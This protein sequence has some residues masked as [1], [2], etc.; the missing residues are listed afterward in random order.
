MTFA[1]Y[2]LQGLV[3][4][5]IAL[6]LAVGI[7]LGRLS[8]GPIALDWIKPRIEEALIPGNTDL[9]VTV[10]RTELRLAENHRTIEL[11]GL[12]VSFRSPGEPVFL[13]FPEVKLTLSV[14]AFLKH[15]L[16]AASHVEARAPSL[17][18]TRSEDGSIGLY[19]SDADD[20][21]TSSDADI[22]AFLRHV[23]LAPESDDRI[24]FLKR[25]QI[26]GGR[27]VY[28]DRARADLLTAEAADL[29]LN[30]W[31]DKVSGWLKADLLQQE[32]RA[33]I[34]FLGRAD[35]HAKR[36]HLDIKATNLVVGDLAESWSGGSDWLRPE[37]KKVRSPI[38]ASI[39]TELDLDGTLSPI[40][41]DLRMT[42]GVLDLPDHL[43]N[44]LDISLGE[45]QGVIAPS[46]DR[47]DIEQFH[48][49]SH[50]A[51]I[52]AKGRVSWQ[53]D[54][55]AIDLEAVA[56][57]VRAEDLPTFWP[58]DLGAD[59]RG[60]VVDNIRTGLVPH[61]EARLD[62]RAEDFG[63]S[64][65]REDAIKGTFAFQGL[66]VRYVDTMPALT[67]GSGTATFN[68]DSLFF[69]VTEG[70][71]GGVR[72]DGGT[73]S[74]SG[75]GKP[76]K[77]ETPLE[78]L[79]DIS[80]PIDR[81]LSVLDHPPLDVA[82][83]MEIAPEQTAGV[84]SA[85]LEV[86]MPI[87]N[88][89]TDEEVEVLAEAA[90]GDVAID[91]LPRL[92]A[93]SRLRNGLFQLVVDTSAVT[94][95]GTADIGDLPLT[96]DIEEP[97]DDG[98]T[99][100]RIS[101]EGELSPATLDSFFKLPDGID[102][103]LSFE[104]VLT[105]TSDNL[106]V[107][108]DADLS[109]L[110][111][112]LPGLSWKKP[113][114]L[115]GNLLASIV[116]PD[117]GAIEIKQFELA[118][119]GLRAIGRLDL[120]LADYSIGTLTLDDLEIG[121]SRG[122]LTMQRDGKGGLDIAIEAGALDLENLLAPDENQDTGLDPGRLRLAVRADHFI[123]KGLELR[124]VQADVFHRDNEWRSVSFE[125]ILAGGDR[126]TLELAPDENGRRL[127]LRSDDAGA[128]IR[129]FDLGQQVE[130][131]D[132]HLSAIL[133]SQDPITAEGRLEIN[134]FTLAGAPLLARLLTVASL[135]G[136]GNLLEGEGIQ[137]DNLILP[138]T[139]ENQKLT[140]T[141]GLLRGSQLGLT[142]MGTIDFRSDALDL[143]GTIIP[144]YSLN[145]LLGQV[146]VIGRILTGSDGRGAFAATYQIDG[147]RSNPSVFVNPL[148]I[149]APGLLRDLFGGIVSGTLPPPE[150]RET[151]D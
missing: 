15:G 104:A 19:S 150:L 11:V 55:P 49:V 107:D 26:S 97:L 111:I 63:Q 34:Q 140:L 40:K 94:L 136:I 92:G 130:G 126:I 137:V 73:V 22:A 127:D 132:F 35:V 7:F 12:A 58:P 50:G 2:L 123:Y 138:F 69:D 61:A 120:S 67:K 124:D 151:D 77:Y 131:G 48:L 3:W 98:A 105:E 147:P 125:G 25:L 31:D 109:D 10:G 80:G 59:A 115:E 95:E 88:E 134:G 129:A 128:F 85:K 13:T 51:E 41:A 66:S 82:K 72:L 83:E 121:T 99:K 106:W 28:R 38:E 114:G 21:Q 144:V 16:I 116:V 70:E 78:V 148:S 54:D 71:N 57:N 45:F 24:A 30:R 87:Y 60:W 47:A 141:D 37:F 6:G 65:L 29:V 18:L 135:T 145:R 139:M 43:A 89:V 42:D 39:A 102:G 53:D 5:V 113:L 76:G 79:A 119:E 27:V 90:L 143:A 20:Q 100:R 142:T 1:R 46:F 68:A 110:A 84:F 122:A 9:D 56:T 146:P 14:E 86:R 44:P 17:H 101:L 91:G 74:I 81:A 8:T 64:L 52:K 117:E 62:L 75:L 36:V 33:S 103:A 133:A 149:L 118:A 93:D 23:V 4:A 32:G 96:L 108:L 112:T